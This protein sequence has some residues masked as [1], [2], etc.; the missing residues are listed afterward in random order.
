MI[1]ERQDANH[2]AYKSPVTVKLLLSGMVES[3]PWA[4]SLTRT[5]DSCTGIPKYSKWVD[6]AP[7]PFSDEDYAFGRSDSLENENTSKSRSYLRKK[8]PE[9]GAFPPASWGRRAD[10]GAYFY[11]DPLD[12]DLGSS[13]QFETAFETSSR[14]DWGSSSEP[15]LHNNSRHSRSFSAVSPFTPSPSHTRSSTLPTSL[16][17]FA[18]NNHSVESLFG[19]RSHQT[20]ASRGEVGGSGLLIPD[21]GVPRAIALYTFQAVEVRIRIYL[22]RRHSNEIRSPEIYRSLKARSS[23]LHRRVTKQMTGESKRRIFHTFS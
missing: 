13:P 8:K 12:Q 17:P 18:S 7:R 21:E 22:L 5:L 4:A 2:N 10:N 20:P 16:N 19:A 14:T 6:D 1:V 15:A 11:D 3:P 23:P 9:Q